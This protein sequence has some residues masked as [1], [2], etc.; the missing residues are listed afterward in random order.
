MSSP[1]TTKFGSAIPTVESDINEK[2][3]SVPRRIAETTPATKPSDNAN[4]R[5]RI[6]SV[7]DLGNPAAMISLTEKSLILKLMPRL[8]RKSFPN[9]K[10]YC[11]P[12]GSFWWYRFSKFARISGRSFRSELNGP[13]GTARIRKNEMVNTTHSVIAIQ[14][15]RFAINQITARPRH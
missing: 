8:P 9:S 3:R 11:F 12:R 15:S 7:A 14:S 6:P 2:S 4:P 10:R 1:A 5:A 13:P